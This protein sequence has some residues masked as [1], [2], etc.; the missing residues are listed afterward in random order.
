MNLE[1]YAAK[2]GVLMPAGVP[3]PRGV[4]CKTP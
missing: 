4:V 3:I 1:E 2:Q